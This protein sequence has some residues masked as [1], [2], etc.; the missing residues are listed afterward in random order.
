MKV[1]VRDVRELL[2][3]TKADPELLPVTRKIVKSRQEWVCDKCKGK[4][5]KRIK[6][7]FI[8]IKVNQWERKKARICSQC[9]ENVEGIKSAKILAKKKRHNKFHFISKD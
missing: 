8:E 2:R 4:I 6:Y 7:L 9:F 5:E 3:G 1:S